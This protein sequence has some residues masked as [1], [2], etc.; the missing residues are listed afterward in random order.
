MYIQFL[1]FLLLVF[2]KTKTIYKNDK[3]RLILKTIIKLKRIQ[4]NN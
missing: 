1:F 3:L 2:K 4:Q